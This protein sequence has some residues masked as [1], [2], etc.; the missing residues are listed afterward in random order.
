[1]KAIFSPS[2]WTLRASIGLERDK[3]V[4]WPYSTV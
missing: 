4:G 1:M 2:L 3:R